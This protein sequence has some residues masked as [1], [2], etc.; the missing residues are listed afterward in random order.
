M[1]PYLD[2]QLWM[3]QSINLDFRPFLLKMLAK[4]EFFPYFHLALKSSYLI[5][6]S[7]SYI[8]TRVTTGVKGEFQGAE[9]SNYWHHFF[10]RDLK[11][12]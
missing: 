9:E 10:A 7:S 12:S 11:A 1:T 3:N 8:V 5:G 4:K 6:H 2:G